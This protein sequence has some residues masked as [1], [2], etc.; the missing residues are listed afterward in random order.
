MPAISRLF[1]SIAVFWLLVGLALGMRMGVSGDHSSITSHAHINLLGWV[2]SALFGIYYAL[3]HETVSMRLAKVHAGAYLIGLIIMLP[4]LYLR[5]RGHDV[6][7]FI[8]IGATMI[9]IG[10]LCFAWQIFF[11]S[12]VART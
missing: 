2:S 3:F 8:G 4:S 6:E 11:P 1:F 10:A 9:C 7:A 5:E 12:K